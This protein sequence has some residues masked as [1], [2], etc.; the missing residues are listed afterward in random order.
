MWDW[1]RQNST[2]L[3]AVSAV[4]TALAA[5]AAVIVI[6]LQISAA[7]RIQRAQTAREIY[8]E[9]LNLTVQ[10][11]EVATA[12]YCRLTDRQQIAA[13]EA[14]VEYLLYTSEQAIAASPDWQSPM[15]EHLSQHLSY[16]CAQSDWNGYTDE[17]AALVA[18]V[19]TGCSSTPACPT[20]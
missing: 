6:P 15:A 17:L 12:D 13:Y 4:V 10:K 16:L 2:P 14:Y 7:D 20:P 3:Q 5:V 1:F 11:P 19:R 8:R 9:F 18:T